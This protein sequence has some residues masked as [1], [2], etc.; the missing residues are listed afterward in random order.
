MAPPRPSRARLTVG[1][2]ALAATTAMA[3][4][5]FLDPGP[6]EPLLPWVAALAVLAATVGVVGGFPAWG[7][8]TAGLLAAEL[9]LTLH[10]RP[11]G[12]DGRTPLAAAGLLLV[13]ELVTWA[14]EERTAGTVVGRPRFPRGALVAGATVAAYVA[15]LLL[16]LVV[17]LPVGRD[18]A[19]S[20]GGAAAVA[21]VT[22]VLLGLARRS[23]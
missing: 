15:T 13:A 14:A 1:A 2:A 11:P 9:L 22:V 20:A 7:P 23:A 4:V 10:G 21:L 17:T 18:L 16:G 19:V 8:V 5:P 3:A 12:L 6:L